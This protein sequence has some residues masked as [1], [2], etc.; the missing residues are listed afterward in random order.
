[1]ALLRLL[2]TGHASMAGTAFASCGACV[3]SGQLAHFVQGPGSHPSAPQRS[4]CPPPPLRT[5][6]GWWRPMAH[7]NDASAM[8]E[9]RVQDEQLLSDS[10]SEE[11]GDQ[12][13]EEEVGSP[14]GRTPVVHWGAGG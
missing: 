2:P 11:S 6:W 12:E 7:N 3:L 8:S 9:D 14:A 4:V 13:S 1:M 10:G 5:P